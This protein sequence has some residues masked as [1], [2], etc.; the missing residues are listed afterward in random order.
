MINPPIFRGASHLFL[1]AILLSLGWGCTLPCEEGE[2]DFKVFQNGQE[3]VNGGQLVV[4]E[5]MV[6]G[7]QGGSH[8]AT[9]ISF[10]SRLWGTTRG[11]FMSLNARL[12]QGDEEIGETFWGS[13]L[14]PETCQTETAYW[15]LFQ[16]IEIYNVESLLDLDGLDVRFEVT[17]DTDETITKEYDLALYVE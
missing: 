6:G 9:G 12:F 3:L 13:N 8:L 14:D 11:Q 4:G 10:N 16:S 1:L 5:V 2:Q 7:A 17:L 15:Q